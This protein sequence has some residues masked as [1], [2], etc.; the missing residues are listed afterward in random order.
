MLYNDPFLFH[1]LMVATKKHQMACRY[2][3]RRCTLRPC[4]EFDCNRNACI[5]AS[6]SKSIAIVQQNGCLVAK[7]KIHTHNVVQSDSHSSVYRFTYNVWHEASII[8]AI[9]GAIEDA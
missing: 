5:E 1:I 2:Y 4:F 8:E 6:D 7:Y 9:H 3:N